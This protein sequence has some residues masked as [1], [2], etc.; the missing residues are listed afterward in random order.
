[1]AASATWFALENE[2]ETWHRTYSI[3]KVEHEQG[4]Q[5]RRAQLLSVLFYLA[6]G[7]DICT[8]ASRK[9]SHDL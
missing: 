2:H 1:M 6:I 7:N 5:Q 8:S 3:W 9:Y 4:S